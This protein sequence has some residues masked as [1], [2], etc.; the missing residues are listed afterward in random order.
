[1]IFLGKVSLTV[2]E[3]EKSRVDKRAVLVLE[4]G[5]IIE[6]VGFGAV[7]KISGEVIF[8]TGMTGYP[9]AITDPSYKGQ[10]LIQTYPL[11]GNYGVCPD[12]FESEGP[13]VEGYVVHE[14]CE[15][16]SH[17]A[18]KLTLNEWLERSGVP[19]I[20]RVDTRMLTKRIRVHGTM[21]GILQVHEA[22][23]EPNLEGL[24]AEAKRVSDPNNR[25]LVSEVATE[26]IR[27]YSV[28]S[29]TE[30][31]LLDCGVKRSIVRSLMERGLNVV[32][33]PPKT[34]A[35]KVLGMDPAGV[36]LSNGPGNPKMCE[37]LI[38]AVGQIA[39]TNVPILG[40]CLGVQIVALSF[41]G[42]TYKLKFGH[43]GQNHP[44]IDLDD[45]RCYITSQNH[46][47]A[48]DAESVRGTG[49]RVTFV[50]ANDGTVEGVAHEEKPIF[51]VQFHPEA[52]PGPKDT[53]YLFDR[54]M[55]SVREYA[56]ADS[57]RQRK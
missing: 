13:K 37:S 25:D 9:E 53:D 18:S 28:G 32:V 24:I 40:L 23:D 33:V 12:H 17:W 51:G 16:P 43:R 47:F 42:D 31:V 26:E 1:M 55:E 46:G 38:E 44:C 10:I 30:V 6:G 41:G 2:V 34:G 39:E 5:T 50:N 14:L 35:D 3:A 48:V 27:R 52:S 56:G 21:L 15:A 20:E 7:E 29:E 45:G 4:D 11:I 49:L 8:N 19:G 22:G 57:S 54:F 36:V